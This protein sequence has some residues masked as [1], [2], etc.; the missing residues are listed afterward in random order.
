MYT[1]AYLYNRFLDKIDKAGSDIYS[2]DQF[3]EILESATYNFLGETIKYNENTQ[4]LRDKL[5][6]L[7]SDYKITIAENPANAEEMI[8]TLMDDYFHVE[9]CNVFGS[10]VTI[11]NTQLIRKGEL[12]IRRHNPDKKPTEEYPK[13][14]QYKDYFAVYGNTTGTHLTGFYIK[15]PT[16]GDTSN[17]II[18]EIAV[19]LPDQSIQKILLFMV[20]ETY[21]QQ[22]DPR[23][24]LSINEEQA[25]EKVN[26]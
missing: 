26:R 20:N 23:Y 15:K 22:A 6:P 12:D 24:Q 17:N 9:S 1:I 19:N 18:T 13:V 21:Q 25:F 7:Y 8:G 2:V 16:F 3:M 14:I 11:R 10:A 4:Q 5:L